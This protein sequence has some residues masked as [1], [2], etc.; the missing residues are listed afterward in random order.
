MRVAFKAFG[1]LQL[2]IEM[3]KPFVFDLSL[4]CSKSV[5]LCIGKVTQRKP[6]DEELEIAFPVQLWWKT[7]LL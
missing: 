2:R 3:K 5:P 4:L 7:E 1:R 6:R